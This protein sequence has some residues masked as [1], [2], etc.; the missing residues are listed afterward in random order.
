MVAGQSCVLS[1][2]RSY[3][4]V[5]LVL[6]L[7]LQVFTSPLAIVQ[8]MKFVEGRY[9]RTSWFF[10]TTKNVSNKTDET[11]TKLLYILIFERLLP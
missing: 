3:R 10:H 8:H 5:R 11:F 7:S 6:L 9:G 2:V 1:Q 4:L